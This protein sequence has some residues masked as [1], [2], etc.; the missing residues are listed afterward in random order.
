MISLWQF[1]GHAL[2]SSKKR[3]RRLSFH[4]QNNEKSS[5]KEQ[6]K[7]ADLHIMHKQVHLKAHFLTLCYYRQFSKCKEN[8]FLQTLPELSPQT[9]AIYA[10]FAK[11]SCLF[12][13]TFWK[14]FCVC[15]LWF[16]ISSSSSDLPFV[17]YDNK[18][19]LG[20]ASLH[21]HLSLAEVTHFSHYF[22]LLKERLDV[23]FVSQL[24]ACLKAGRSLVSSYLT[25]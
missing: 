20:P 1:Q 13:D 7:K 15:L 4:S 25:I 14:H 23:N 12:L 24:L 11:L 3:L 19:V 5:N 17:S 8:S 18:H 21:Q 6:R 16:T 9:L 2:R 10:L 22:T